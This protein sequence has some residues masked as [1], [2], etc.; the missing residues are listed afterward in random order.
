MVAKSRRGSADRLPDWAS[1]GVV[2]LAW[3]EG[4]GALDAIA[5]RLRI[6]REGGYV[7]VD[8]VMFFVF[9]LLSGVKGG[10]KGFG[11]QARSYSAQLAAIGG[12]RRLP[13]P[14]SVSRLLASTTM[15][16]AN[17]VQELL[18]LEVCEPTALLSH[19][20]AMTRDGSGSAWHV[21]DLDPT[22]CV[23][24]QRA[25]PEDDDLPEARRRSAE[26]RLGYSG[27]KRGDVQISR[28]T[29]QHAGSS[30]WMGIWSAPGNGEWREFSG[31]A[32]ERVRVVCERLGHPADRALVRVDGAGGNVPFI[33]TCNTNGVRYV[34]RW[35]GYD[36]LDDPA[37]RIR[38][39]AEVWHPVS[40]SR[41][42]PRREAAEIGWMTLLAGSETVQASGEPYP[43]VRS[44]LVVSRFRPTTAD[45]KRGAGILIDGWH[46]EIYVTD[47][48]S[49]HWSAD[50]VVT[51]YY[52]RTG[53]ENRFAQ[54]D[55]VLGLDNIFSYDVPGQHL[56]NLVGLAIWNIQVCRGFELAQIPRELPPQSTR[57]PAP[58]R[59]VVQL[60]ILPLVAQPSTDVL[61]AESPPVPRDE[62]PHGLLQE[63]LDKLPWK[64]ILASRPDWT[65]A[66]TGLVCPNGQVA[67]LRAVRDFGDG[68]PYLRFRAVKSACS[69]CPVRA[70]C[71]TSTVR[72]FRKEM[73]VPVDPATAQSIQA[74]LSLASKG[75]PGPS[76]AIKPQVRARHALEPE[77]PPVAVPNS[78]VAPATL[79]P[80]RL[81][82]AFAE[83][84]GP[85]DVYV[86]VPPPATR[87]PPCIFVAHGAADRQHRRLTWSKRLEWNAALSDV[88]VRIRIEGG[89]DLDTILQTWT[90]P[91]RA[92]RAA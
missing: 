48:P 51:T 40:D 66:P 35:S 1:K 41:S 11:E 78:V 84:S 83:A 25:L 91:E 90:A 92:K 71:T 60:P 26:M 5:E 79:L 24:R 37:V 14:A 36:L 58:D 19:P 31:A 10:I 34:T 2:V 38:L 61:V 62:S 64:T 6:Q 44:R 73:D 21:F 81:R 87:P 59:P 74:L 53:M 57:A 15:L 46:Y 52:G 68:K 76:K 82:R 72:S 43:A 27:R 49:E 22:V 69:C 70:D 42:G 23:V 29:L 17:A 18:L 50:E 3:L 77:R 20:T 33:T 63:A 56:A 13:T 45:K 89:R 80:A 86:H 28:T 65:W 88:G 55:R 16:Q 85:I 39:N 30:L 12:R 9:F 54:E 32:V 4:R 7:G 67:R 75:P 8:L 47:L